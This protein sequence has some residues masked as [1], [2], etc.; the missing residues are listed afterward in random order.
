[1]RDT[2]A[3][4]LTQQAAYLTRVLKVGTERLHDMRI[5]VVEDEFL[6]AEVM[7]EEL[8]REGAIVVGPVARVADAMNVIAREELDG[9][10]LDVNLNGQMAYDVAAELLN[11][12][13]RVVLTTGYERDSMPPRLK[14]L[15]CCIKPYTIDCIVDGLVNRP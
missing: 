12:N 13:V 6:L 1:V 7:V 9:A 10:V 15:H 11:R 8:A 2:A 14:H 4:F 5:L 3:G